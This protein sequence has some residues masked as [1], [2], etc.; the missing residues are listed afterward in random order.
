M[1][2]TYPKG[3][4]VTADLHLG[5]A[6]IIKYCSRPFET[7][8]AMH[9]AIIQNWNSYVPK[10]Q[11]V[12][13]VGDFSHGAGSAEA[14]I[15][16]GHRLNGRKILIAG[17]HD[18]EMQGKTYG[19]KDYGDVFKEVHQGPFEIKYNKRRYV[20]FHYPMESWNASTHGSIHLHGHCHGQLPSRLG[21]A[22]PLRFGRRLDIGTDCWKFYPLP[23]SEVERVIEDQMASM[24]AIGTE[25]DVHPPGT[26]DRW[27]GHYYGGGRFAQPWP[28]DGPQPGL[29][30]VIRRVSILK[31]ERVT[32]E[33][34]VG[35]GL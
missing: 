9:E 33:A 30:D 32:V 20:L 4:F 10:D 13:V 26:R 17:N 6:N 5:H 19:L 3:P 22:E 29:I 1:H 28:P 14:A 23:L 16:V 18:F 7:V 21:H 25:C 15:K 11:T 2:Y 8:E 31:E 27:M 35:E 34:P 24:L 12:Y